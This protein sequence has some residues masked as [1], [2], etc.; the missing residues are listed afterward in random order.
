MSALNE[1]ADTEE[2]GELDDEPV[3]A[4]RGTAATAQ[5]EKGRQQIDSDRSY[6]GNGER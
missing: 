4:E 3:L 5:V 6:V 1:I 2:E